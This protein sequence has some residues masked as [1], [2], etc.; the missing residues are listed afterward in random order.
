M[1]HC[2]SNYH[3]KLM[4]KLQA[5]ICRFCDIEKEDLEYLLCRC[6]A[7]FTTRRRSFKGLLEPID[8]SRTTLN[9][10]VHFIRSLIPGWTNAINQAVTGE[11]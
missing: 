5:D 3:L 10:V 1:G 4:G 7:I 9:T 8:I 11:K 2:P 6:P